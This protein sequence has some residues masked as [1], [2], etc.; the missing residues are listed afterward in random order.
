MTKHACYVLKIDSFKTTYLQRIDVYVGGSFK[1]VGTLWFSNKKILVPNFIIASATLW[2]IYQNA[3][4][5]RIF[6]ILY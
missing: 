3:S 5:K 4:W 1:T 2:G 6:R